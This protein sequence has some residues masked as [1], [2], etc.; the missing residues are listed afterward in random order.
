[1]RNW[2]DSY[3]HSH[4]HPYSRDALCNGMSTNTSSSKSSS[5]SR[6]GDRRV[7]APVPPPTSCA[8]ANRL[9]AAYRR[10][11]AHD[12]EKIKTRPGVEV[13]LDTRVKA[14]QSA[15]GPVAVSLGEGHVILLSLLCSALLSMLHGRY[16]KSCIGTLLYSC[17]NRTHTINYPCIRPYVHSSFDHQSIYPPSSHLSIRMLFPCVSPCEF[18]LPL[19]LP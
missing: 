12:R 10:W 16:R 11:R 8:P 15:G 13:S 19:R 1:M 5:I 17:I 3:S 18:S 14:I 9:Y 7:T 6:S 4:S 2:R